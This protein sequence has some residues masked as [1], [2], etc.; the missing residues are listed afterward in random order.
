MQLWVKTGYIPHARKA[1]PQCASHAGEKSKPDQRLPFRF[2][3]ARNG[4]HEPSHPKQVAEEA[5]QP[6]AMYK[7][8][9]W[10]QLPLAKLSVVSNVWIV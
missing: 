3:G 5:F 8:K 6:A 9:C 7:T 2:T 4:S 1:I 10:K